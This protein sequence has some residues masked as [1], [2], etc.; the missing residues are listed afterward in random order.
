MAGGCRTAPLCRPHCP[1]HVRRA[2][3]HGGPL[4]VPSQ[5]PRGYVLVVEDDRAI[6]KFLARLLAQDGHQVAVAHTGDE[7]LARVAA[8]PPDLVL[9]DLGLPGMGGLEVCRRVKANPGTRLTPVL[10]LT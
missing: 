6:A 10:I 2:H 5:S 7:A 1:S 4:M 3:R 8:H 9:L